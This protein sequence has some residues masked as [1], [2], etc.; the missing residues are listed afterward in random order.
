MS[1]VTLL[2]DWTGQRSV[3]SK[4]DVWDLQLEDWKEL[5]SEDLW[6]QGLAVELGTLKA[7]T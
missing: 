2:E 5:A 3:D 4:V 1:E 7:K 6:E